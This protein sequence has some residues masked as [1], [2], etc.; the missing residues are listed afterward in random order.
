MSKVIGT[1]HFGKVDI[2]LVYFIVALITKYNL[3]LDTE[4]KMVSLQLL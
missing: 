3:G 4:I 1:D 2:I